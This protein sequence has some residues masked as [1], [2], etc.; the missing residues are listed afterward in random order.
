ML[1]KAFIAAVVLPLL[2]A[3]AA[4]QDR[5]SDHHYFGGPNSNVPHHIGKRPTSNTAGSEK[6]PSQAGQHHYQGGPKSIHHI[7]EMPKA[8]G[9]GT[10]EP[11][12]MK[13]KKK[14]SS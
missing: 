11:K 7:G 10:T 13:R 14:K 12:K 6:T 2:V 9:E 5:D 8:A 3:P 4:A 1:K